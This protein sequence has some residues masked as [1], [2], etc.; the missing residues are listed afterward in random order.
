MQT[1]NI[2]VFLNLTF[3]TGVLNLYSFSTHSSK[4]LYIT[5]FFELNFG[6]FPPPTNA[7]KLLR[8]DNSQWDIPPNKYLIWICKGDNSNILYPKFVPIDIKE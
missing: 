5:T 8:Y 2:Y 7:I 1:I 6:F 4:S 3:N